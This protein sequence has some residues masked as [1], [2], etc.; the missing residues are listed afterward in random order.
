MARGF[1]Y[2]TSNP[3]PS[4][5]SLKRIEASRGTDRVSLW[6]QFGS[7]DDRGGDGLDTSRAVRILAEERGRDVQRQ[8]T[9]QDR[10]GGERRRLQNQPVR[11]LGAV[12]GAAALWMGFA[13]S[14]ADAARGDVDSILEIDADPDA[15]RQVFTEVAEPSCGACHTLGD[16][17]ADGDN[18]PNLDA[19]QPGERDVVWSLV[20]GEIGAHEAQDFATELSDQEIADVAAYV[21]GAAEEDVGR[22][23][24]GRAVDQSPWAVVVLILAAVITLGSI[25]FAIR[26]VLEVRRGVEPR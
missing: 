2:L 1:T 21:A 11:L 18:A 15:G 19:V 6:S 20:S 7:R 24:V 16:A 14:I 17:D 26:S 13:P 9:T 3:Y 22:F 10:T 23:D 8:P 4:A 12:I 25:A 5:I